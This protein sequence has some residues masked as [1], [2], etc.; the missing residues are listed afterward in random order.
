MWAIEFCVKFALGYSIKN[1][2]KF[3]NKE[4]ITHVPMSLVTL[5]LCKQLHVSKQFMSL[6]FCMHKWRYHMAFHLKNSCK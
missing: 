4:K 2:K 6:N 5:V 1:F 3:K